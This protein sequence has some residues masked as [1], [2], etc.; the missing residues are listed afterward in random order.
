VEDGN[1]E[2]AR[3]VF[4]QLVAAG[5]EPNAAV[6]SQL[7]EC[8][9]VSGG[10]G[11]AAAG[12]MAARR[13]TVRSAGRLPCQPSGTGATCAR[14]QDDGNPHPLHAPLHA[15][16]LVLPPPPTPSPP[17]THPTHPHPPPHAHAPMHDPAQ[18][19]W[20]A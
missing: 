14:F 19:T 5:L 12:G 13:G 11:W 7:V 18:A 10:A 8:G 4:E 6:H 9:V 1:L 2:T 20:R 16:R 3:R 15:T 17:R